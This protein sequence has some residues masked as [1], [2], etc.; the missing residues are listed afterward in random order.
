MKKTSKY[1]GMINGDWE[2]THV[3]VACVQSAYKRTTGPDGRK[4]RSKYA[5]HQ[6]YYYIFERLT[7]DL[8][9]L[10]M[11]R[12]TAHQAKQVLDGIYTVEDF[13][14]KKEA[15]RSS[16]FTRKVSYSFCN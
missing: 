6:Q 13:A 4:E 1:L 3:G 11:I 7:S 8:K 16:A 14:K 9:A 5:G 10:K 12:L 15:R 2:C